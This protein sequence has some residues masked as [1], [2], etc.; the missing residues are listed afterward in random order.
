MK[1]LFLSIPLIL[2]TLCINAKEIES[3]KNQYENCGLDEK[4]Q[5]LAKLLIESQEQKRPTLNCN[6][7]LAR[8][9]LKKAQMMSETEYISHNLFHTTPN[10]LLRNEGVDLPNYYKRFGNQVETLLGGAETAKDS[11]VFFAEDPEYKIHIFGENE[12]TLEQDQIGIGYY[13]DK[14]KRHRHYWAV[15]IS[16]LKKAD[17]GHNVKLQINPSIFKPD[18]EQAKQ[19]KKEKMQ[20][21]NG[22]HLGSQAGDGRLYPTG[23][24]RD[25]N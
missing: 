11:L 19:S 8:A 23:D 9:A 24:K 6:I 4:S 25:Q 17:E 12:L 3:D 10:E 22:F 15:Y 5:A 2:S 16:A 14:D 21:P 20:W 7:K 18:P 1:K 13:E